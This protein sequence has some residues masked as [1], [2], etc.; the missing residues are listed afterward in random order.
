LTRFQKEN[1]APQRFVSDPDARAARAYG[2]DLSALGKTVAKRATFVIGRDGKVLFSVLEW[3]P[4][5]NVMKT[6]DWLKAHPQD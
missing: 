5:A 3:S 6:L 4:L 2:V 1:S